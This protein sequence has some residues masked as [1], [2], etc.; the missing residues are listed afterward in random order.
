[1]SNIMYQI[2]LYDGPIHQLLQLQVSQI[3]SHHHLQ[4]SEKLSIGDK[5]VLVDIIN[6][7]GEP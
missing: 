5:P 6:L 3:V 1:M 2:S 7:E 4:H